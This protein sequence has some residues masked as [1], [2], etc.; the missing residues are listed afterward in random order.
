[1]SIP[2]YVLDPDLLYRGGRVTVHCWLLRCRNGF[3]GSRVGIKNGL[4]IEL[5]EEILVG[6]GRG[7]FI[8]GI[9]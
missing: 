1:M 9:I 8:V 2:K 3:T 5:L 7:P 4:D 6:K